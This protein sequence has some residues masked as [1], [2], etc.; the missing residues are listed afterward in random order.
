MVP[1]QKTQASKLYFRNSLLL[2]NSAHETY[3]LDEKRRTFGNAIYLAR[4]RSEAHQTYPT[5]P[6]VS[7]KAF[8]T[9][10]RFDQDDR[11][12]ALMMHGRKRHHTY[13]VQ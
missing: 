9:A 13:C 11:D 3:K 8:Y 6:A 10:S 12:P 5:K 7:R 2:K 4:S 1:P